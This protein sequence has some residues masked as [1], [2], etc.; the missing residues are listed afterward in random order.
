MTFPSGPLALLPAFLGP[1][2]MTI[3]V[4]VLLVLIFGAKAPELAGRAGES[5]SKVTTR[6]RKVE[7]EIEDLKGTPDAVREDLGIDDDLEEIEESVEEVE[8]GLDPDADLDGNASAPGKDR[9]DEESA[10]RS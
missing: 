9:T 3:L 1:A 6:K 2:E 4:L 5:V 8:R 7:E 10:D